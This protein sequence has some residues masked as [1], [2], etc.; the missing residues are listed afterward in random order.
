MVGLLL[1]SW[2][3]LQR[4]RAHGR[5]VWVACGRSCVSSAWLYIR[6]PRAERASV[7]RE[8]ARLDGVLE[9]GVSHRPGD[10]GAEGGTPR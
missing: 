10:V 5:T 2:P 6:G 3:V 7:V 1:G 4:P 9:G 8:G